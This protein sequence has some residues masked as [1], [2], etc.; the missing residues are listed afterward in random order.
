[1]QGSNSE[2]DQ[3]QADAQERPREPLGEAE[4]RLETE[5]RLHKDLLFWVI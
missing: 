4:Q 1:M 2:Q 5:Q 3:A